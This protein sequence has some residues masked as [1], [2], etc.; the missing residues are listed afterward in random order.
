METLPEHLDEVCG[1]LDPACIGNILHRPI[2]RCQDPGCH[3]QTVDI[4]IL[5]RRIPQHVLEQL[6]V[7]V[8]GHMSRPGAVFIRCSLIKDAGR[9]RFCL[10]E[11]AEE[12]Y[13]PEIRIIG[14]S[15]EY[16]YYGAQVMADRETD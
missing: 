6:T 14:H 4:Q 1:R 8:F 13:L 16:M 11:K 5:H 12:S 7:P 15:G 2:G 3:L 10:L 9:I